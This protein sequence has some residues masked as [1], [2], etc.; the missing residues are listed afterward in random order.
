MKPPAPHAASS[1]SISEL[2]KYATKK[3]NLATKDKNLKSFSSIENFEVTEE[4]KTAIDYIQ[5]GLQIVFITGQAGTGKSV[6]I[7]YLRSEI[8]KNCVVVA[9]TGVAALNVSG[10]TIHSFFRFAPKP[11]DLDSIQ[12][13]K[14]GYSIKN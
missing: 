12:Q 4:F 14:T 9:P 5:S 11:I 3:D 2:N 7:Q 10:Q 1:V 8:K 13:V 6:F